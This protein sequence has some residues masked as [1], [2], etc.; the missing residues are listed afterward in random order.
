MIR[1]ALAVL[2]SP[3]QAVAS[4]N[5][6]WECSSL[7]ASCAKAAVSARTML[8]VLEGR[9]MPYTFESVIVSLNFARAV[10]RT[11]G[12]HVCSSERAHHAFYETTSDALARVLLP[13]VQDFGLSECVAVQLANGFSVEQLARLDHAK[14]QVLALL[15][16]LQKKARISV[17]VR[18]RKRRFKIGRP[19]KSERAQYKSVECR[20]RCAQELFKERGMTRT[21]LIRRAPALYTW[22]WTQDRDW[23]DA[24]LPCQTRKGATLT[25][26][27]ARVL[28]IALRVAHR[29][30]LRAGG[31]GVRTATDS[32]EKQLRQKLAEFS[33]SISAR[34][35]GGDTRHGAHR[36]QWRPPPRRTGAAAAGIPAPPCGWGRR[37]RSPRPAPAVKVRL[38]GR[39]TFDEL[40]LLGLGHLFPEAVCNPRRGRA[41]Q[42]ERH[43]ER[44]AVVGRLDLGSEFR[45]RDKGHPENRHGDLAV[46]DAQLLGRGQRRRLDH[47]QQYR[48]QFGRLGQRSHLAP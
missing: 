31:A 12:I 34:R 33:L 23:L 30:S 3:S 8:A 32:Q 20:R 35:R 17:E 1:D 26:Q 19:L 16:S 24:R 42:Q 6:Q 22:L 21:K 41:R 45:R 14:P 15:A 39:G 13:R 46:R 28:S 4:F 9:A 44:E 38:E 5:E 25:Q 27:R 29:V 36:M 37:A 48:G 40:F 2:K 7:E 11:K 43:D 18:Q 47:A 10:M